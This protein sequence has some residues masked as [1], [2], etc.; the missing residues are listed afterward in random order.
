MSRLVERLKLPLTGN[1][2]A[3]YAAKAADVDVVAAYP[4]TPQTPVV[5]KISEFIANGELDA[6]YIN[7]ESE[8]SA[9]SAVVGA[10]AV[11][12]RVFTATASQ[13]LELMYEVVNIASGLRLPVVMAVSARAVSAPVSIHGDYGDV[14]GIRDTGWIILLA[15]SAQEVY[16]FVIVAYKIAENPDV[17]LPTAVAYDGFI[18]SHVLEP[19]EIYDDEEVRRFIPKAKWPHVLDPKRP[20]SL[21]ITALP[22]WYYEL[23]YQVVDALNRSYTRIREILRD[24]NNR[25]DKSYDVVETYKM[26]DAEYA[27]VAYGAIWGFVKDA[28][29]IARSRG[30]KIGG[31]G[32]KVLRPMPAPELIKLLSGVKAF[33]V[34]DKALGYSVGGPLY[35]DVA[36]LLKTYDVATPGMS[37]IHGVG[38]RTMYVED[39]LKAM[40]ELEKVGKSD[41]SLSKVLYL[42]L[43]G[44]E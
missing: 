2:A 25:F 6:E 9:L 36:A 32:L 13:G 14:M 10:A 24:F 26:E 41:K 4:I 37:V 23:R 20:I 5:E 27:V 19:V 42:G 35:V 34:V 44:Y 43:R 7:V 21:G 33:A 8:H 31:V 1:Y 22:E 3:A 16:D 17:L 39:F 15:S 40:A 12:A 30:E 11:G 28:I 38:Q 29:D 18:T